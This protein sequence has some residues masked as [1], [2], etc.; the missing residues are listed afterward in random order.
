MNTEYL[1]KFYK[2]TYTEKIDAL[3]KAELLTELQADNLKNEDVDLGQD[4][5]EH[6]I[7]NY[8]ENY[9]LPLGVAMNFL[10][11]NQETVVPMAIEEPSVIAAASF[12]A[13]IIGSAGGFTTSNT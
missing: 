1:A 12:A 13:K 6:M 11:D 10:I 9:S 4:I 5:G 2:K 3:V 7:E 8:I